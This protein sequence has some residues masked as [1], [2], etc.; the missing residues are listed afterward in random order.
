MA[1][2]GQ[3]HRRGSRRHIYTLHSREPATKTYRRLLVF[4]PPSDT[5]ISGVMRRYHLGDRVKNTEDSSKNAKMQNKKNSRR[6][7]R[8]E[9]PK[10][11]P[12]DMGEAS[13]VRHEQ[14]TAHRKLDHSKTAQNP[15][16]SPLLT[17]Q[18]SLPHE[19]NKTTVRPPSVFNDAPCKNE[20]SF[21]RVCVYFFAF[22][23]TLKCEFR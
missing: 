15:G 21:S 10:S 14:G 11:P 13:E 8:R 6:D 5:N 2:R 4:A 20:N 1:Y 23:L 19:R 9:R 3:T 17:A 18:G 12:A 22:L 16:L 7:T